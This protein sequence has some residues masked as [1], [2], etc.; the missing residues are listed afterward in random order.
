MERGRVVHRLAALGHRRVGVATVGEQ[1]RERA[2]RGARRLGHG[3]EV[4][5]GHGRGDGLMLGCDRLNE[6]GDLQGGLLL[7]LGDQLVGTAERG[8]RVL[9][10][11]GERGRGRGGGVGG[12][13]GLGLD[14]EVV[15]GH[16]GQASG[17]V[18]RAR[19]GGRRH[20]GA[21]GRGQR[22]VALGIE[23]GRMRRGDGGVEPVE[24]RRRRVSSGLGRRRLRGP[25]L[26]DQH[27]QG[28]GLMLEVVRLALV[29]QVETGD[30]LRLGE[31]GALPGDD[32]SQSRRLDASVPGPAQ[33]GLETPLC[34]GP[35]G[36]SAVQA[37]VLMQVD[38]RSRA[39][40]AQHHRAG[41]EHGDPPGTAK[42]AVPTRGGRRGG[43]R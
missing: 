32:R 31:D 36:A 39:H 24:Q 3:V 38:G 25:D 23:A 33:R 21:Q 9:L 34:R 22:G 8:G 16:P 28:G 43:Q 13:L 29:D 35:I 20:G 1:L 12:D 27:V 42:S 11:L 4:G 6:P 37:G 2:R 19:Q 5:L 30:D 41:Q 40:G 26:P 10:A 18:H 17:V 15:G 14:V 7:G